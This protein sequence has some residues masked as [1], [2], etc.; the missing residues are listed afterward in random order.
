MPMGPFAGDRGPQRVS[1][2]S[3][4]SISS[5]PSA[6]RQQAPPGETYLSEKISIPDTKL[7]GIL[8]TSWGLSGLTGQYGGGEVS[9]GIGEGVP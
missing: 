2:P 8:E 4:G 5:P 1:S 9:H 3:Y 6:G 7:V